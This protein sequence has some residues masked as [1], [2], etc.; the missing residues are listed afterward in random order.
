MLLYSLSRGGTAGGAP[1]LVDAL[2][3]VL[4]WETSFPEKLTHYAMRRGTGNAV[5]GKS[6]CPL[7][8]CVCRLCR[9]MS[10]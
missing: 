4:G 9:L 7:F 5:D 6:L 2:P 1:Y 3:Q 10:T 8:L